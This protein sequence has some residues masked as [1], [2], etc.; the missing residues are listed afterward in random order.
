SS[1]NTY[2]IQITEN[3]TDVAREIS[4]PRA[5]L[6]APKLNEAGCTTRNERRVYISTPLR[7]AKRLHLRSRR[8]CRC[9][10][11]ALR[12][13]RCARRG[14]RLRCT[15]RRGALRAPSQFGAFFQP[16][17]IIL[18]GIDH[19]R[20]F[21]SVMAQAAQLTADHFVSPRFDRRKPN[22]NE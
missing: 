15:W 17:L 12:L 4:V 10:R 8:R 6:A 13:L 11:L 7:K 3:Y 16:R 1:S 18:G 22:R 14:L 9:S 5:L 2:C 21:H 19:E 20:A